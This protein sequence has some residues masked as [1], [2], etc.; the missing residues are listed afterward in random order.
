MTDNQML[1]HSTDPKRLVLI[2]EDEEINRNILNEILKDTYTLVFASNGAEAMDAVRRHFDRLSVVLLDLFLPD[3]NGLDILR[4]I[5]DNVHYAGIPVII[6]TS[7]RESEVDS[8]NLGAID[9]IPKP[10]PL[11][12]VIHARV[13][14]TIEF[15]ED[16]D[17][18]RSTERD[19]LTGLYNKEFFY[20]YSD[21]YDLYH[22]DQKMDAVVVDV[23]HFHIINERYGRKSADTVLCYIGRKLEEL[24]EERGGIACRKEADTFFLYCP[25]TDDYEELF[26]DTDFDLGNNRN[27]RLRLRLGVYSDV[28]KSIEIER[29]FDRAKLASDTAKG[30]FAGTVV[31]YDRKLQES[32]LF[33][34][35]LLE[36]FHTAIKEKQF[37]VYYQPK[38]DIRG[39]EPV[40]CS[41]CRN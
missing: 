8:L 6:L 26:K 25:H 22:R 24:V 23:N 20:T 28:D 12:K 35:Q 17:I 14:R 36:G 7:D 27:V 9:F 1:F 3:M 19:H 39:E 32:E 40:L 15:C 10:Y 18:I 41:A 5:K 37:L 33:E 16:R 29:R 2:V 4:W 30:G 38:F 21:Q 11:P 13:R 34:E 31:Y